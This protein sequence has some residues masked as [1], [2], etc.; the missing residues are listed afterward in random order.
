[1]KKTGEIWWNQ[2]RERERK[3]LATRMGKQRNAE[4]KWRRREK[5][6][7]EG[8]RVVGLE[9]RN[10]NRKRKELYSDG[11]E[12]KKEESKVM[13]KSMKMGKSDKRGGKREYNVR[14]N[15]QKYIS[16]NG[17]DERRKEIKFEKITKEDEETFRLRDNQTEG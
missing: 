1:M 2:E 7:G 9:E 8:G 11:E 16:Q 6:N 14:M 15:R 3:E 17:I 10:Q 12:I 5:R 4:L 13:K